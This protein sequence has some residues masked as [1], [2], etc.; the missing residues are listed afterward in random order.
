M[1]LDVRLTPEEATRVARVTVNG[2]D[3]TKR[4]FALDTVTGTAWVYKT[5][6]NG[7]IMRKKGYSEPE[8]E[9]KTGQVQVEWKT[10]SQTLRT[11]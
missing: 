3:V 4:C 5:A 1:I 6:A 7:Q 2:E 9:I 11:E 10:E 8:F